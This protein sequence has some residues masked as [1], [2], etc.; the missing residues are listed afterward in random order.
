MARRKRKRRTGCMV[1]LVIMLI[2]IVGLAIGGGAVISTIK[3]KATKAVAKKLLE[4]QIKTNVGTLGNVDVSALIDTMD[5]KDVQAVTDIVDKYVGIG[6]VG[7]YVDMVKDGDLSEVKKYVN[8]NITDKDKAELQ[9]LYEKYKD[10][11]P[12]N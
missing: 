12:L 7:Q 3:T 10:Q 8:E 6:N 9:N 1:S 4:E 5:D 11:I 2:V